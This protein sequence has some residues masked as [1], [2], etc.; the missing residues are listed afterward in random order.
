MKLTARLVSG[1]ILALVLLMVTDTYLSVTSQVEALD[2]D[3]ASDARQL[4]RTLKDLV[5]DAWR[6]SGQDTTIRLVNHAN[7]AERNMSIRWVWLDAKPSEPSAPVASDEA[8][9]RARSGELVQFKER[10]PQ[11]VGRFITYVPVHVDADRKGALV[12]SKRL[13]TQ[14]Q[15]V[16]RA[17]RRTAAIGG[18]SVLLGSVAVI[19]LGMK[20]V[21]HPLDQL[22]DK[23]R[24]IGGGDLSPMSDFRGRDELRELGEALNTM[25]TQL[26]ESREETRRQTEARIAALEQLR[27]ADR[28]RTVGQLASGIAHELGTPLN[29][30]TGQLELV[31]THSIT[32]DELARST[33]AIR[34]QCDRMTTLVRQLLDFARQ[35]QPERVRTDLGGLVGHIL[36]LLA[37]M[38]K[39]SGVDLRLLAPESRLEA[40]V[41]PAQIEQVLTNIVVNGIQATPAGGQLY[42]AIREELANDREGSTSEHVCIEVRD[43]GKGMQQDEIERVFDPFFTTK[44]I[45]EGTG[46]GLSIAHGIIEEHSGRILVESEPGKGTRF[47]VL[48]PKEAKPCTDGS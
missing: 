27:H 26:R 33:E 25:C 21:G 4:G 31:E 38:V 7:D 20:L 19:L 14:D 22:I 3:M 44:D 24:R 47:S 12:L 17:V 6:T 37:P 42:V 43:E 13:T 48:L 41:D 46:L 39:K 16:R 15:L 30:I 32:G 1:I 2:E 23:T 9:S 35:R 8:L 11:G 29:I 10:D 28:L 40:F 34:T 45:G 5:E 36:E 18:I